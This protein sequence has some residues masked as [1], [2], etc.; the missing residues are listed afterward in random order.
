VDGELKMAEEVF[1]VRHFLNG[2]CD[3]Q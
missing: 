3:L 2:I 1:A